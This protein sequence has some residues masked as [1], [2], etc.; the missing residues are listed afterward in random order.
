MNKP[1]KIII[2]GEGG[3]GVQTIAQ[4]LALSAFDAGKEATYIPNYGVEQRGGVSVAF[5]QICSCEETDKSCGC[6][7]G[8]PKFDKADL[9]INLRERAVE[10]TKQYV[11][12]ETLYVYDSVLVKSSSL[13]RI[14]CEKIAIPA[15]SYASEKLES[16]VF[17]MIILGAV[18]EATKVLSK[19]AVE[20]K[21]D[22]FFAD[23]YKK[24]P[25]LKHL[26]KKALAVGIEMIE[27]V[28]RNIKEEA[29]KV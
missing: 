6:H 18:L 17:N 22:Q 26:N 15:Q 7:I 2:T 12:K 10:R 1:K 16:K 13:A 27:R 21:L 29:G 23:K 25:E 5:V 9:L 28:N 20:K 19:E 3:Q 4:I 24:H 14:S 11:T 8:F